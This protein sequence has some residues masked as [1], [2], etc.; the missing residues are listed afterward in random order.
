[1]TRSERTELLEWLESKCHNPSVIHNSILEHHEEHTGEWLPKWKKWN[2]WLQPECTPEDR[3][4][5]IHGIPGAGKS[6]LASVTVES[7]KSH[8]ENNTD[9]RLGYAYYYCRYSHKEDAGSPF[10]A[11]VIS[12]LSRQAEWAPPQLKGIR[13]S[14]H[15]PI[16]SELLMVLQSILQRFSTVYIIVDGVDESQPRTHMLSVLATLATDERFQTVRLV[17]T[18]R[19]HQDIEQRFSG[20]SASISMSNV[21]VCGDIQTVVHKWITTSPRMRCWSHLSQW[22]EDRLC[23]GAHGM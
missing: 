5:W 16:I 14:G 4:L 8:C 18:S 11:W 17:A 21:Y 6:V 1:M 19:L 13:D 23:L 9:R 15:K 12:R 2:S 20:I 3:F 22:I 10:L 7:I